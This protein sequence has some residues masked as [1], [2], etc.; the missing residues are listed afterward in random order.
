MDVLHAVVVFDYVA[1]T[2]CRKFVAEHHDRNVNDLM[3]PGIY[4]FLIDQVERAYLLPVVDVHETGLI[5]GG[6]PA[7]LHR[8]ERLFTLIAPG[9]VVEVEARARTDEV[10]HDDVVEAQHAV[11]DVPAAIEVGGD[12]DAR[13]THIA[14]DAPV[15]GE[16]HAVRAYARGAVLD[17]GVL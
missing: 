9:E 2:A 16:V 15:L 12:I 4:G 10:G 5:H 1:E 11:L 13:A 6:V 7:L 8:F 3:K 14:D 17:V